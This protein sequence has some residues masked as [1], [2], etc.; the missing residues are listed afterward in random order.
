[1][2]HRKSSK[3]VAPTL[4]EHNTVMLN[5]LKALFLKGKVETTEARGRELKR[6]S[7]RIITKAGANDLHSRRLVLRVLK[8]PRVVKVLFDEIAPSFAGRNGGYTRVVK[9]GFRRGDNASLVIVS[10]LKE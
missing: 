9:S 7:D 8:E 1:M 3:I 2:R 5:L 6:L 10:L 4:G